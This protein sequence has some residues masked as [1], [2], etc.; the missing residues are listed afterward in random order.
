MFQHLTEFA[1]AH[2]KFLIG[3]L[4]NIILIWG[5]CKFFDLLNFRVLLRLRAKTSDYPLL[6]LIP[7][8]FQLCK[9]IIA[10]LL[11]AG[12]LQN[13]GYNVSS[14]VAGF[15]I[16]GLAVAFAAQAT[17]GNVFGS[18]SLLTD[19]VY[20][21]GDYIKFEDKSGYVEGI[22]IRSTQLRTIEGF[23]INV[24]NNLLSNVAITNI[25]KTSKYKIDIAIAIECDTP[26]QTVRKALNILQTIADTENEI[27]EGALAFIQSIEDTAINLKLM[28]YT[29][30]VTWR[31]Y[32]IL[33]SSVLEK[34]LES[35]QNENIKLDIPD[36]R[37]TF[38]GSNL[39]S[40]KY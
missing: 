7:I 9:F 21:I 1:T 38:A 28:G 39:D 6:T 34:I 40:V 33:H 31:D 22:N 5:E 19:K 20:K 30:A 13:F 16:T 26:I 27:E 23:L 35:F 18:F 4:V 2:S 37:L 32:T 10:C 8:V 12:F 25:S 29:T 17:I 11:I 14:I 24:P 3:I 15:G 36:S